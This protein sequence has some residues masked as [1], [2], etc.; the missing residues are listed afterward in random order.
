MLHNRQKTLIH[1]GSLLLAAALLLAVNYSLD[2][3][4]NRRSY[5]ELNNRYEQLQSE[6]VIDITYTLPAGNSGETNADS[7]PSV[8]ENIEFNRAAYTFTA[9]PLSELLQMNSH[10]VGWV[11]IDNTR[12]DYP[13]VKADD[14]EFYLEHGFNR[15]KNKAGAIFMDYRNTGA[16]L[17]N[18]IILYG[19]YQKDGSMFRDLH[20]FTDK[21]FYNENRIINIRTLYGEVSYKIFAAYPTKADPVYIR[22]RLEDEKFSEFRDFIKTRTLYDWEYEITAEDSILTLSTCAYIYSDARFVVHAVRLDG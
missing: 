3:S 2:S 7:P 5:S 14:N 12:I 11:R 6:T 4:R 1:T 15:E 22:T 17:D 19:H 13:V 20:K 10:F 16:W 8:Q 9:N 21:D 18:H